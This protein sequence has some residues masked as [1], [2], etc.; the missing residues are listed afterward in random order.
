MIA[1]STEWKT[2]MPNLLPDFILYADSENKIEISM[3]SELYDLYYLSE[4]DSVVYPK[5]F[6]V[7][8]ESIPIFI[9]FD[10]T[11]DGQEVTFVLQTHIE[12]KTET[13]LTDSDYDTLRIY[14]NK[15]DAYNYVSRITSV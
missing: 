9:L 4:Y 13:L 5:G 15:S 11:V 6:K 8:D 2:Q 14:K 10:D 1:T 12:P 3:F 7:E